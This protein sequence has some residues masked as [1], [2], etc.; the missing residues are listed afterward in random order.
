MS[1][2]CY[3]CGDAFGFFKKEHGCK[4]CGYSFCSNCLNQKANIPKMNN[5]KH[6]VCLKCFNIITKKVKPPEQIIQAPDAYYKRMEALES[7]NKQSSGN[8]PPGS[9]PAKSHTTTHKY[10]SKEDQAIAE[11]LEKLKEAR[12]KEVK[13]I[14][15][16]KE[17]EKRLAKLKEDRPPPPTEEEM[18]NRLAVLKGQDTAAAQTQHTFVTDKRN[19]QE[20]IDDLMKQYFEEVEIDKKSDPNYEKDSMDNV[21]N[22]LNFN[23]SDKGK[24]MADKNIV[25]EEGDLDEMNKMMQ[26]TAKEK[27]NDATR[28]LTGLTDDKQLMDKLKELQEQRKKDQKQKN[29]E[30]DENN[31]EKSEEENEDELA[32]NVIKQILEDSRR[33]EEEDLADLTGQIEKLPHPP[34]S[35]MVTGGAVGG[36]GSSK[37]DNEEDDEL[38]WCIICNNDACLRCLGCDGDL[39]CNRC[40]REGHPRYELEDHKTVPFKPK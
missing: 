10:L 28:A 9:K 8:I 23:T 12:K 36:V 39:Y 22:D 27:E 18:R 38:P 6:K 29:K 20:Q 25:S 3:S 35:D 11:R 16:T 4:N 15:T 19:E 34:S 40:Y 33:E 32:Q 21:Q 7:G 14:P 37:Y 5:E 2:Q 30:S 17:M 31:G 24:S 13:R 1:G 26:Q